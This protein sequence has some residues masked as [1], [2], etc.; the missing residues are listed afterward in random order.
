MR[1]LLF[2]LCLVSFDS[3]ATPPT[4][5]DNS[6]SDTN[7]V[8]R[9]NNINAL[10]PVLNS[11]TTTTTTSTANY[12]NDSEFPVSTSTA[13]SLVPTS[14]CLGGS[15]FGTQLERFGFTFGSAWSA[16]DCNLRAYAR[17]FPN[18]P[19]IRLALLCQADEVKTA[20]ENAGY[21]C[22]NKKKK[23][24]HKLRIEYKYPDSKGR[25]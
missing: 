10:V 19:D 3:Y 17:Q 20:V 12:N 5:I 25:K 11:N 22:P 2:I 14:D 16:K 13:P 4:W 15:S 9:N 7:A 18:N 1:K 21:E 8:S 24:K 23:K 6:S